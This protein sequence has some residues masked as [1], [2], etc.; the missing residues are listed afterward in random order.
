MPHGAFSQTGHVYQNGGIGTLGPF[1]FTVQCRWVP[2]TRTLM[3][4]PAALTYNS[5][6]NWSGLSVSAGGE[7]YLP[8]VMTQDLGQADL[9]VFDH[10]P[11]RI[12]VVLRT[13]VI[14]PRSAGAI[15]YRRAW[16]ADW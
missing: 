6:V 7:T 12:F 15:P 13:G 1:R 4:R 3:Q 2:E 14:V 8:P 9:W 10:L 5:H 11:G 16:L